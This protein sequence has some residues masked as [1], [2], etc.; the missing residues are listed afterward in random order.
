M[1]AN[2]PIVSRVASKIR[3]ELAAT[4]ETKIRSDDTPKRSVW[5]SDRA[6]YVNRDTGK[7]YMPHNEGEAFFVSSDSPR[8]FLI[9]G[10]EG[11]GKSVAGIVKDLER[12]RRGM[13][14]IMGSPNFV[15]FRKSLWPEFR[16]WCP[17]NALV[18]KHRYRLDQE[19]SPTQP[20][21]L[22]FKTGA[23]LLCGGFDNPG[24]WEGPNVCFAHFDEARHHAS[25]AMVKVF[26][27]R[28]RISGPNGEP[29]Q[30]WITT[31]PRKTRM[32]N[33]P[34]DNQYHWLYVMFGPWT[35]ESKEDPF[36]DFKKQSH[37]LTLK[38]HENA[39]NLDAGYVERRP[40][41][42]SNSEIDILVNAEWTEEESDGRF[43]PT[44][45]WWDACRED[46]PDVN[47][48]DPMIIAL[49][50]AVGRSASASDNFSLVGVTRHP[51]DHKRV[52]VREVETWQAEAGQ[53]INY[54]GDDIHPGPEAFLRKLRRERNIVCVAFDPYQLISMAQRM[55]VEEGLWFDQFGQVS[56]RLEADR[57]LL[58]NIVEKVV[59]HSGQKTL[60]THIDNADRKVDDSGSKFRLVKGRGRI[61]CAVGLSMA[62]WECLN[63]NV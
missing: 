59:V 32:S 56:Q 6:I 31:T 37:V 42:L 43:L 19:W 28:C 18:P 15:H 3:D 17:P 33:S 58:T 60:W 51:K 13:S 61:D 54:I 23:T 27:G 16:R 63:L 49:D 2:T 45:T 25:S 48:R 14:G 40:E 35:D 8:R 53:Q 57:S 46:I 44:M 12:L 36:L 55:E 21:E 34:D 9:K 5:L 29:A 39:H 52:A 11:S 38:L 41:S 50:A 20:F 24:G 7:M 1:P 4:R 10:G 22:A 30:W 47:P 62:V 26:D